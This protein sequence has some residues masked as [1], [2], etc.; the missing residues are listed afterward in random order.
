M[1]QQQKKKLPDID[2]L[3]SKGRQKRELGPRKGIQGKKN[4]GNIATLHLG[5]RL[6]NVHFSITYKHLLKYS[7][8]GVEYSII[9]YKYIEKYVSIKIY[10]TNIFYVSNIEKINF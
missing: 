2:Y 3:L 9:K 8:V 7:F 6:P 4:I 10:L 5:N 1:Q